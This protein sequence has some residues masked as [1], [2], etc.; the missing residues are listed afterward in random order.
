MLVWLGEMDEEASDKLEWVEPLGVLVFGF[1]MVEE[2]VAFGVVMK[3]LKA[4]RT[5]NDIPGD[6]FERLGIGGIEV[7]GVVDA[8]TTSAPRTKQVH[9]LVAEESSSLEEAK[10]LLTE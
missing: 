4:H 5:T 9:A 10:D 6:R 8:K 1:G 3:S 2:V 7:D